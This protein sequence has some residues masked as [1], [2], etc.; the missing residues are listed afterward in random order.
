MPPGEA[1]GF[2]PEDVALPPD[3]EFEVRLCVLGVAPARVWYVTVCD[4]EKEGRGGTVRAVA[5]QQ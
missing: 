1:K 3:A 5:W 4:A 2:V